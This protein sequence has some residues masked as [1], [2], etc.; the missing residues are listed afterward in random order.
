MV[1]STKQPAYNEQRLVLI[2]KHLMERII[3]ITHL[4]QGTHYERHATYYWLQKFM[5]GSQRQRTMQKLI[6]NCL[7]TRNDHKTGPTPITKGVQA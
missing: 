1:I 5:V 2:P 7:I 3:N 6:R 4:H